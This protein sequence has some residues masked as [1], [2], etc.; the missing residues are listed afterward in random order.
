[1]A[2]NP[3]PLRHH[4]AELRRRLLVSFIALVGGLIAAFVFRDYIFD[5]LMRP[6]GDQELYVYTLTGSIGPAM[7]V[8]LLGGVIVALPVFVYQIIG[9]MAPALSPG[10]RRFLN[11]LIPGVLLAFC[12]GVAFAYFVL[13]PPI[14]TFLLEFGS[15]VAIIQP[16]L[17]SYINTVTALMFWMGVAFETPFVMYLLS[18]IGITSP[19]MYSKFRR[20]WIVVSVVLGAV[21]TPTFDPVNQAMVAAPFLVLY[22]VGILLSRF[23]RRGKRRGVGMQSQGRN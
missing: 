8:A 2:D 4:L 22:E 23:A 21:I 16:S 20:P 17:E 3:Q 5:V 9:F 10:E 19:E 6:L 1:M 15:E 12:G 18:A 7:K 14:V 13:L 11:R